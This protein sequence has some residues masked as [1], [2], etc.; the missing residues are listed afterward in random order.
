MSQEQ[1]FGNYET[2]SHIPNKRLRAYN[3]VLTFLKAIGDR[4][5]SEAQDYIKQFSN[6]EKSEI[7]ALYNDIKDRGVPKVRREITEVTA[8][9]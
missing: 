7:K 2:F 6:E 9:V 1:D 8:D 5:L 4:G 3:R